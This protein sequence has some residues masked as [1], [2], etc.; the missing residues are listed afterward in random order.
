ML[1]A[2]GWTRGHLHDGVVADQALRGEDLR[3]GHP[4]MSVCSRMDGFE[5]L[6]LLR[7]RGPRPWRCDVDRA[8]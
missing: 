7:E 5:V 2:G 4:L 3:P 1:K 6:R 8:R